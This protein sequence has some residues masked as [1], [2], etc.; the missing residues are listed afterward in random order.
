LP[1]TLIN[2]NP[3]FY[4]NHILNSWAA[5]PEMISPEARKEYVN[6][7]KEPKVIETICEEYRAT[8]LDATNDY[9][10]SVNHKRIACPTL[11][12][13]SQQDGLL[14]F[15]GNPLTIW[16]DWADNATGAALPC[17]HFLM[18]ECPTEVL[19]QFINFFTTSQHGQQ[20]I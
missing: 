2:A 17:G 3:E 10:D 18:E 16:K 6:Y 15:F 11:V 14:D 5:K 8:R 4:L 12:L 19:E 9:A 7:F 13:W 1:E 20:N